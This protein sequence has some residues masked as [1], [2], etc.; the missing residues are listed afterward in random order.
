MRL[1]EL[2]AMIELAKREFFYFCQL[3]AKDFYKDDRP[4]LIELC[5]T[6]QEFY[7]SDDEVL[8]LNTPPR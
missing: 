7:Y 8:I 4:Y 3:K 2:G 1:I 5:N 6:L